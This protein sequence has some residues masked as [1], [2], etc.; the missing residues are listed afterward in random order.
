MPDMPGKAKQSPTSKSEIASAQTAR[1]AM[2][3]EFLG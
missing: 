3:L 1:L 2:T